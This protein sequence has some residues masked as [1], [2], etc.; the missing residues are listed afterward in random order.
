MLR[1][2][3][4]VNAITIV[5]DGDHTGRFVDVDLDVLDVFDAFFGAVLCVGL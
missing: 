5:V 2:H 4:D 3:L 1:M